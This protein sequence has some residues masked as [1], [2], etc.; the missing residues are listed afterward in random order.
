MKH[1]PVSLISVFIILGAVSARSQ[2]LPPDW[3]NPL[4]EAIEADDTAGVKAI[5]A[6]GLKDS[7]RCRHT[8]SALAVAARRGNMEVVKALFAAGAE[9]V[10][11]RCPNPSPLWEASEQGH[12]DVVALLLSRKADIHFK[13]GIGSTPLLAALSGPLIEEGPAGDVKKTAELLLDAG[14]DPNVENQYGNTPLLL[15]VSRADARLVNLLLAHGAVPDR[16]NKD[17]ISPLDF[18]G[19]EGLDFIASLL[20]GKKYP[21]PSPSGLKLLDA[22]AAGDEPLASSLLAAEAP[23]NVLD[24][25]GNTP[26]IHA[27]YNGKE[28]MGL[29]LL[30]AGA[31][32]LVRNGR[33]DTALHFAGARGLPRLASAL[34]DKGADVRARDYYENTGLSYAVREGKLETAALLLSRGADPD[35]KGERGVSLL[36]EMADKGNAEM[37]RVLIDGKASLD[38]AD[39]DGLTPLMHAVKEG[40]FAA[41]EALLNAGADPSAKDISGRAALHF[42][43][44]GRHQDIAALLTSRGVKPD[45][46]ALLAALRNW[47]VAAVETLLEQGV[48]P[49]PIPGNEVPLLLA[50]GAYQVQAPLVELLLKADAKPDVADD[51]GFTPLMAAAEF[52]SADSVAAVRLLL[53]AGADP[54]ARDKTG[55]TAWTHAMLNGSNETA[56]VLAEAGAAREYDALAWEGSFTQDSSRFAKAV[57]D[58]QEWDKIWQK[59]GKDPVSPVIDFQAYAVACVFLGEIAGFDTMGVVFRE[60]KLE[61]DTLRVDYEIEPRGYITDVNSTSPYAIKVVKRSGAKD[62]RLTA[63]PGNEKPDGIRDLLENPVEY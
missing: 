27:A 51:D 17:G 18:A 32:P 12:A 5:L 44:E 63:L 41:A 36:M 30:E 55:M 19:K 59:L 22:A 28:K 52:D 14:S 34:L 26:L 10:E 21:K 48:S 39:K 37:I 2:L 54:G 42:A 53:K 7:Q 50:A 46:D 4:I 3:E 49:H 23:V 56:E 11:P 33:N 45:Q 40:K 9:P 60:P 43:L 24:D 25:G 29:M 47:D 38:A 58:Q 1:I 35:E 31:D 57:T 6:E 62:V 13:V 8:E 15:A 20:A 16:K 61:G